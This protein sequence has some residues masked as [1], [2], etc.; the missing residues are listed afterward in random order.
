MRDTQVRGGGSGGVTTAIMVKLTAY[1]LFTNADAARL[2]HIQLNPTDYP[3]DDHD[4]GPNHAAY[5]TEEFE[6]MV[7]L[8]KPRVNGAPVRG[9]GLGCWSP[10]HLA[11]SAKYFSSPAKHADVVAALKAVPCGVAYFVTEVKTE[12]GE[13]SALIVGVATVDTLRVAALTA[14]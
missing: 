10:D 11:H 6:L 5:R 12:G 14:P 13:V 4:D 3:S 9:R 1:P 2:V 8:G 7:K